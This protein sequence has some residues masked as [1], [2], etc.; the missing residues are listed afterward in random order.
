MAKIR[1][2]VPELAEVARSELNEDEANRDALIVA[3]R[4]W[5]D[6]QNYLVARTEDQFLVA[7]LRF[8][9][10]DLEEAK[11]RVLFFYN[12]KSKERS[13]LKCR[14]V[15]DKVLE[16]ARS[17]IFA[18][19]PN[20][21]GPGGPRIH[22][23]RMGHIETSKHSVSDIFRFHAF[24]SEIEINT[25][26]NWNIAGVVEVIDFT[27]IPYSLLLQF[28]PSLFK[29]MNAFLEHGLP[30]SLVATHIV[31]ASRETQF[32]LT[33]IRNVMKQKE[34]LHIH[35]N[36]ESLYKAIGKEYLPAELGGNNGSLNEA[37]TRY[38]L[39]LNS[40]TNYFKD[41]ERFGV[42]EKLRAASEKEQRPT[43]V[44]GSANEDGAFR[45]L[46]FD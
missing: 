1:E 9:Q 34:L 29:R 39:Q 36:L 41:E 24:R 18:T 25:D 11:K 14:S 10:W 42:D 2:L 28:D 35:P 7:F 4:T 13:L 32:V 5:I 38:E 6:E 23:T 3:L 37:I 21:I 22:Y 17:G 33:I 26:D 27:K 12:Y 45:K 31:N 46:T 19:L 8:C 44:A 15:D 43:L 16:L 40:F 20:P 30:T